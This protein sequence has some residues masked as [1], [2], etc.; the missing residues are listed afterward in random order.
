MARP[1]NRARTLIL[2][3]FG[4][5]APACGPRDLA[6]QP[7]PPAPAPAV[8]PPAPSSEP[9]EVKVEPTAI[10]DGTV[11]RLEA[12]ERV[13][14]EGPRV[15][16]RAGDWLLE[17]GQS[18]AVVAADG[19]IIDLGARGERDELG[20]INPT[21]FLGL[22]AAHVETVSIEPTGEGG[23]VLHVVR[24]VL[25]KPLLLHAFVSFTGELL[26]VETV[27][28]AAAPAGVGQVVTLG[29]RI[30]WSNVPTWVE[31]QGPVTHAGSF[32]A[33]FVGRDS[34]GV[35]YALCS[36]GG[37]MMA[38]F[39]APE[40]GF[41]EGPATGEIP[42]SVPAGGP[43]TRRVVVLAHAAGSVGKAAMA[44]S[45]RAPGRTPLPIPPG[46][47][48]TAWVEVARCG[49][50][51][52]EKPRGPYAR[53]RPDEVGAALPEGCFVMRLSAP[54]HATTPWFPVG[55]G[56]GRTLPPSGTLR[57][58]VHE[59]GSGRALPA[60]I[61]VRGIKGTPDPDWG[62][63]P[64]EGA[65]LDVV[66]SATGSGERPLP[67]GRYRVSIGRGFEYTAYDKDIE[68]FA[69]RTATVGVELTRAVDTRGW[70]AADLHLHAMPSPDAI[71]P[72]AD[73]VRA[74][75]AT[76]VEV[77]VANDHNQVTDYRPVIAE[78]KLQP[79]LASIVGDEITTREPAWG[80]FNVFPL[81]AGAAPVRFRATTPKALL[82]DA[83]AAGTLGADTVVQMNHPR[84]GRIG[85]LELLRFDRDDVKGWQARVALGEVGF[86]AVEVFNGDHYAM[87]PKVEE[88]LR[89]WYALLEAGVRVTATGNSD[90]HKLTFHEP[91]VPRN[92]V[93]V[94]DDDPAAFD[95]RAF[96]AAVRRGR[97]V[98]SSGPFIVLT[99][100]GKGVGESVPAGEAEIAVQV[101]APPW[102]DVDRV[103]L[104]RRG[105]VMAAWG[106]PFPKG[107]H[108]FEAR[109][110]KTLEKG[111][112]IVAVAR[113]S[114][115]MTYLH[116]PN[117]KPFAFT[118]PVWVE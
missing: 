77:G 47:P 83:R 71:Q 73:R 104:V 31:G 95:E 20:E 86:D 106:T 59:R 21:V 88:C 9:A 70:I 25:E 55:A 28:V 85:Y 8:P 93:A 94:P 61:L 4:L 113:G 26:R 64:D 52:A 5:A 63:D 110:Q 72:L 67:P 69:G 38:R 112:W 65:A 118:N 35:A 115:A 75:A 2:L 54:G 3:A 15:Q 99:V 17:N 11:V 7:P 87:I 82:Q 57:F 76:G 111:D 79:F 41:H 81:R 62:D 98:V 74:L 92:L 100:G 34:Y 50:S 39:D 102:V 68:I 45:C 84:M 22:D 19:R 109:L 18:V 56:A 51:V 101:D 116:R 29:E 48:A 44:L 108:R 96:V 46:L 27:V 24:R 105:Q 78:L 80:H 53:F 103:E 6:P 12:K 30:D 107:P 43:G 91:G 37:R 36:E 23:R 32:A 58:S 13:A 90:S 66:Y 1:M 117:A 49:G 89:D 16:A 33:E 14:L 42:E 114:K 10:G 60:R 97:V 40:S